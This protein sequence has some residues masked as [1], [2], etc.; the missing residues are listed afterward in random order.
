M[1]RHAV[2]SC[3]IA[4]LLTACDLDFIAPES[5]PRYAV[6]VRFTDD[7]TT[8]T[9]VEVFLTPGITADGDPRP[10]T[11]DTIV[12][13]NQTMAPVDI[14]DDGTRRYDATTT[15]DP[16]TGPNATI[17]TLPPAVV[18]AAV[19]PALRLDLV[20]RKGPRT[21]DI[22]DDA[23]VVLEVAN[24]E[25]VSVDS[26]R[27]G[28]VLSV[29][30][31]TGQGVYQARAFGIRPTTVTIPAAV[32]GG[33]EASAL[34]VVVEITY[35]TRSEATCIGCSPYVAE[36]S[37]LADLHWTLNRVTASVPRSAP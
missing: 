37:L 36:L 4:V 8:T 15:T 31:Q 9:S 7:T 19:P 17:S 30:T 18:G 1:T 27:L 34:E 6:N 35:G 26:P 11:N 23:D 16:R 20:W 2:L 21:I 14:A 13:G 12:V 29:R 33:T 22:G 10:V 25:G 3:T 32:I 24:A 5:S 28:W